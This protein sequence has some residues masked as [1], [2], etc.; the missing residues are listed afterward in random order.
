M[1]KDFE[2]KN[3]N[4]SLSKIVLENLD[5]KELETFLKRKIN[6]VPHLF[7]KMPIVVDLNMINE[8]ENLIQYLE[9]VV[10]LLNELD[11]LFIG[12]LNPKKSDRKLINEKGYP[13]FFENRENNSLANKEV[14]EE[15]S[16]DSIEESSITDKE[17]IIEKISKIKQDVVKEGVMFYEGVVRSGQS[18]YAKNKT[19]VILGAVRNGAEIIS[20]GDVFVFGKI[21][22][23]VIAGASGD[24]SRIIVS[25][26]LEPSLIS[27]GGN[28]K[29][30]EENDP[31][32]GQEY[33]KISFDK[34]K[35]Q[36]EN[37]N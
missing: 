30:V 2:I 14:L 25:L 37:F 12:F 10:T 28:Y 34:N 32:L 27:I 35:F 24:E 13:V 7:K 33:V 5:L 1:K 15:K 36:I 31:L 19:L 26:K 3:S 6:Q 17:E 29:T 20:D 4:I 21:E 8:S 23:K 9:E 11:L 22:G 16:S 18:I